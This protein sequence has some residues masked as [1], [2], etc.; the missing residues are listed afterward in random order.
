MVDGTLDLARARVLVTN[1]DGIDA[2]GLAVLERALAGIVG[3]VWVVAPDKERSAASHSLTIRQP[4]RLRRIAERRYAVDG[5]P[6]DCVLLGIHRVMADCPPDLVVSGINRGSNL[7]EDAIYS[8]TVGAAVEAALLGIPA[9]AL[10]QVCK[11]RKAVKW[12]T[13]EHWIPEILRRL[14]AVSWPP[15]VVINVNFPDVAAESVD[16]MRLGRLGRHEKAHELVER[17]DPRGETYYW[18]GSKGEANPGRPG[19]DLDVASNGTISITP[20]RLDLT[21]E[22]TL[23]ALEKH[24]P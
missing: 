18:V 10:S 14:V 7:G 13:A 8:G 11:N 23:R 21:D 17:I 19:S 6:A 22:N 4:L 1:D 24:F 2:P 20:V 5:T 9:V 16:G 3:E 12:G 15:D